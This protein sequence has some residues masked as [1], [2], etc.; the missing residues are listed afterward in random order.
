MVQRVA[1]VGAAG[2]L[3]RPMQA[4]FATRGWEVLGL[5]HADVDITEPEDFG[6][7]VD[8]RP[9]VVVNCAAWTDVD[10]C[11]RNP[12]RANLVN[13]LA[14]GMM[15]RACRSARFVQVSTNEVFAG[16]R[17]AAYREDDE[18]DPRSAYGRSKLLGEREVQASGAEYTIIRTAWLF[19][20]GG[21]NFV[22]KILRAAADAAARGD[23]LRV[24]AD[25]W[26][27]PTWTP[28]LAAAVVHLFQ[29]VKSPPQLIHLAGEP[30]VTRYGWAEAVVRAA[31]RHTQLAPIAA[32]DYP[33]ASMPPL[34][35]VLRTARA[36][37]LGLPAMAWRSV[38]P[39]YVQSL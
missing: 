30:A 32:A 23:P 15:A 18:P 24:V 10:G 4:A 39:G 35:A 28:D 34:R 27:N 17:H 29:D 26:G 14:P 8:W 12:A 11:A 16:Q 5:T 19:G 37:E 25:E 9:D 21:A 7:V 38:L 22:T 3:G 13:G 2:Q 20:P 6:Q 33:R 36:V 31:S 1:V